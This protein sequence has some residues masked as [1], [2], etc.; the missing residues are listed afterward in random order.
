MEPPGG[1]DS[2]RILLVER[3]HILTTNQ[4]IGCSKVL[5]LLYRRHFNGVDYLLR[6]FTAS[7][8]QA[9]AVPHIL[10]VR[11]HAL[12]VPQFG[13]ILICNAFAGS[14]LECVFISPTVARIYGINTETQANSL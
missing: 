3:T 6:H 10:E 1:L 8:F 12:F 4:L 5:Y 11:K 9:G 7:E 14:N 13:M 2:Q